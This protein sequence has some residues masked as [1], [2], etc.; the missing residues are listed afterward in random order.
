M[1]DVGFPSQIR[2]VLQPFS[3]MVLI[4][5][6]CSF[7]YLTDDILISLAPSKNELALKIL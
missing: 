3:K 4:I 2:P 5:I 7:S 1:R 6:M